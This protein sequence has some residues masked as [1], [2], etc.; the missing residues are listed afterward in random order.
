M[1]IDASDED[2]SEWIRITGDD[3]REDDGDADSLCSGVEFAF[4]KSHLPLEVG[5]AATHPLASSSSDYSGFGG[6][7]VE[8]DEDG[9]DGAEEDEDQEKE[10]EDGD[11][12][13]EESR[14]RE[15]R[16]NRRISNIVPLVINTM[17]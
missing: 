6:L 15:R 5:Q 12:G 8:E 17:G 9:V 4:R 1:L 11:G 10:M 16:R 2:A 13:D 14:R 3:D 7:Y